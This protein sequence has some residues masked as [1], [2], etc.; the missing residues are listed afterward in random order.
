MILKI[1]TIRIYSGMEVLSFIN[2][3]KISYEMNSYVKILAN[4]KKILRRWIRI[5]R[6]NKNMS[7]LK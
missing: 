2:K 7:N 5:L 6:G 3:S 4:K 1:K